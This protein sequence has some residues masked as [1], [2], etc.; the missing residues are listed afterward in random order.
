[1]P[2]YL[3]AE[4]VL[5][6]MQHTAMRF[7]FTSRRSVVHLAMVSS[8]AYST[9]APILYHTLIVTSK[10]QEALRIFTLN[11]HQ[12]TAN[13]AI[14]PTVSDVTRYGGAYRRDASSGAP[15]RPPSAPCHA[16]AYCRAV[17][18][19]WGRHAAATSNDTSRY[20]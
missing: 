17:S 19:P 13:P 2:H 9:V 12:E 8:T 7:R 18:P 16:V 4:V 14:A 15:L 11:K 20:S 10:N 3:P 5:E 6:I 1:M